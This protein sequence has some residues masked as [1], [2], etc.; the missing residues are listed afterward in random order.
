MPRLA[1]Q[2][3]FDIVIRGGLVLDGTGAD[4]AAV[5]IAL[6]GDR[7]AAIGR[8]APEQARRVIDAIGLHVAPG[9]IDIHTHSDG[10][11]LEFPTA[12]GRVRQ[13]ITT[14]ITGNC[15]G[16]ATPLAGVDADRVRA[17]WK[18]EG[19]EASWTGM[20]SYCER[21]NRTGISINHAQLVGQG[22]LRRNAVGLVDRPLPLD[23]LAAVCRTLDEAMTEGA[24]GLSTGLEYV[25]G[26]YTPTS[27]IVAM[28]RVVARHGGFYATHIRRR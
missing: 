23:E 9:F 10:D 6:R 21:L 15:G 1:A 26:R 8:I 27:E 4:A 28:S 3:P 2:A 24:Y 16:S 14:E 18:Q 11:I 13:G 12:D 22:T 25:P 19:I 5:D 7:I 20:A 17:E